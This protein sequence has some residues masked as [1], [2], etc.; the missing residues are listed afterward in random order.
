MFVAKWEPGVIPV[1]SE[2]TSAPIW[3]E[4]RNVPFQFFNEEGL[5]HIAGLVGD[6]K[7][8]HPSTANKT[9]L[10]VAKVFTLIDPRKL[11]PE[12][13]NAQFH[14]GEICRVQM[15]S[16]WMPPICA[17]CKEIGHSLRHCKG[18]PITCTVCSSTTHTADRCKQKA[19]HGP[20]KR[21]DQR[22]PRSKTPSKNQ[23]VNELTKR[24]EIAGKHWAVKIPPKSPTRELRMGI[25]ESITVH[26]GEVFRWDLQAK[27]CRVNQAERSW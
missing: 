21:R 17:H 10:E 24:K 14:S 26:A 19:V 8:L 2:L 20:K 13:V 12:A 5:E 11:L 7:F 23:S 1:K 16:P 15:S 22:R 3:L 9:N 4:V 18:A 27:S 25:P 6:P